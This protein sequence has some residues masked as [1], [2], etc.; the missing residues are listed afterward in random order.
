MTKLA[1]RFDEA[2]LKKVIVE[3]IPTVV[4]PR[5]A[6]LV[7][8]CRDTKRKEFRVNI[9]K[10]SNSY[11]LRLG[12]QLI[13]RPLKKEQS[14]IFLLIPQSLPCC[15]IRALLFTESE[16]R[17]KRISKVD[18]FITHIPAEQFS[19]QYN[20]NQNH[21]ITSNKLQISYATNKPYFST[22]TTPVVRKGQ[23]GIFGS[24][25]EQA[26]S[27]KHSIIASPSSLPEI[28]TTAIQHNN[29]ISWTDVVNRQWSTTFIICAIMIS[30]L[31]CVLILFG[32]GMFLC[33]LKKPEGGKSPYAIDN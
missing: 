7:G 26:V 22:T 28:G 10:H 14:E 9:T 32:F 15:L 21:H 18:A 19:T 12:Q 25:N 20:F 13:P 3:P 2:T 6:R 24:K 5:P 11:D 1:L 4:L 17:R 27:T 30:I 31:M 8:G 16:C 23:S 29:A 33:L